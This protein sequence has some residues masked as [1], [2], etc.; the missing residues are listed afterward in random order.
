VKIAFITGASGGIGKATVKKFIENGYYVIGQYYSDF[1]SVKELS[2]EYPENFF[3]VKMD[4]TNSQEISRVLDDLGKSFKH[5]DV[6][7]N[8]AGTALYK[9][10]TETTENEW[11]TLFSVNMKSAYLINNFA[12]KSMISNGKGKIVNVSSIWGQTGASMEVAYS[13]SKGAIISYTKALAKELAPSKI[14]VN[15]VCPGVIDTKMNAR[16]SA[17]ELDEIK[18]ETPL[19][20]LGTANEVAE[21]I[22][23][24]CSEKADFI[25]GQIITVDGGFVL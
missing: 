16:L 9:L 14:N 6:V 15:C 13:A 10:I 19:G 21:L 22:W 23:F 12:L 1:E 17:S 18:S 20:R 7:V 2:Q 3:A 5:I 24:L 25:T 11:D 4:L 8:N